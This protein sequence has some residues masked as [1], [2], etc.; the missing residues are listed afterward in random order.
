MGSGGFHACGSG[1]TPPAADTLVR[2]KR[3][4][5]RLAAAHPVRLTETATGLQGCLATGRTLQAG[6]LIELR[7]MPSADGTSA[8]CI[9]SKWP[10]SSP[11]G[12]PPRR[13]RL[14]IWACTISP[15][16]KHQ[17]SGSGRRAESTSRAAGSWASRKATT[18][19]THSSVG[20]CI[21]HCQSQHGEGFNLMAATDIVRPSVGR[22]T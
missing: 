8:A 2:N 10:V 12:A 13:S 9:V 4:H 18:G 21:L 19:P 17:S 11:P 14:T 16:W 3:F 7:A 20:T 5:N 15:R 6:A 22:I 1:L